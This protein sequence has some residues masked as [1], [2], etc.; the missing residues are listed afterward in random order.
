LGCND[1]TSASP[2]GKL[3]AQVVDANGAGVQGVNADLYKVIEGSSVLWRASLTSSNGIAVFGASD[4]GVATGDYFIHLSF[5]TNYKLA[6][7]ETNDKTVTVNAGD[8]D[9]VT[10]HVVSGAPGR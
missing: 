8:D 9:V 2:V 1:S 5:I 10:F 4:G 7:G 3:S 6:A